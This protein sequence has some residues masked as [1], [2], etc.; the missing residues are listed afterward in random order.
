[1]KRRKRST[2]SGARSRPAQR[3]ATGTTRAKRPVGKPAAKKKRT[4]RKPA[5]R[6]T[7][8]RKGAAKKTPRRASDPL[9]RYRGKRDFERTREPSGSAAVAASEQLRFV[10]HK[11]AA[12]R[13]HYDLR[14]ELDGTFKS[15]AVTRGPSLDPKERRL[16]V[17]VE[18]H[19][20][21]YGDFE[22]TIPQGEYGGGT[23]QIWDRGYWAP[24]GDTPPQQALRDGTLRFRLD[25]ERLRGSWVLVRL[26][27]DRAKKGGTRNNWLLIKR[28]D[29]QA[30]TA[31]ADDVLAHDT[32][33]ASGRPL[34]QI[35]AGTGP[36]PE[37]FMLRKPSGCG[38]SRRAASGTKQAARGG[39]APAR[40]K[41]ASGATAMPAFVPPQLAVLRD[42]APVGDG[43][44][45]EIKLDGYRMQLRVEAGGAA[46]L[47]RKGLDWTD[48]FPR[49]ARAASA[50][51]DCIIDGE[52]VALRRDGTT[53]FAALQAAIADGKTDD[54][55]YF[56]FDLLFEDGD[57]LRGEPL[58][59]RKKRLQALL[60][61][62]RAADR[63]VLR[64]VEHFDAPG[65]A[66][67]RSACRMSLE[68]II[69][70]RLDAPY[71][72]GRGG[73]WAKTKC[74]GGQEVVI[75]GWSDTDGRFRSLLVG[76]PDG[77]RLVYAGR[78]GTGFGRDA[79]A[80]LL[81]R[82]REHAADKSPFT[83]PNAPRPKSGVHWLA[84]ALVA[85]IEFAGWTSDGL[86]RQ[87]AFK[88]LRED[89]TPADVRLERPAPP[90]K[91]G[92][93][94]PGAGGSRRGAASRANDRASN[95]VLGVSISNPDKPL[96]P[97]GGDG[98]PVTKLE[99]AR[100]YE[101]LGPWMITHL[102]GRPC[103]IIRAPDGI[104]GQR[105]FQRHAMRGTSSLLTLTKVEGD[106]EPYLQIDSL[107]ALIAV[108]QL[109]AVE[110]HPWN[111]QPGDPARPGRLVFDIDPAPG[112][113]FDR[114][115][116]AALEL[117]E[118]IEA[119]GLVAF[120]KTTGGKGL[121]VVTPLT[122]ASGRGSPTWADAKAFAHALCLAMAG[123]SPTRYLV[124]MSKKQRE[125]RIFLDYLR[126]DRMATAVAPLSPRARER[127]PVSMPVNWSQV[128][129]GLDPSRY[130]LR[131]AHGLLAR[132]APWT[133]Y[134]ESERPLADAIRRLT[135]DDRGRIATRPRRAAAR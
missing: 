117:R 22:G 113:A 88:G 27:N 107:E 38:R 53:D 14:L 100:Y 19:P 121:H 67:L 3:R 99:L 51:P 83:G 58:V 47:T 43:W 55:V 16:A 122:S 62:V 102:K 112:V 25:G 128:R 59:E 41:R 13:L 15:W 81:P 89:K 32:S 71:R 63:A 65:D 6:A 111:C 68:G 72:P 97:D 2:R 73:D 106:R 74:R 75:G 35:A 85:E 8:A 131:T 101:K 86:V 9:A 91:A 134:C 31:R 4:A 28:R 69:S 79:V 26:A 127:A 61:R 23:V 40:R 29:A 21:D 110:L 90:E 34:A 33:V 50:L 96:W 10:V 24:E 77:D 76:I 45:H 17:E 12:S 133:D 104:G 80:R 39:R 105:F 57:D 98:T 7:A 54:L 118:R 125:G 93:A 116:A 92:L 124:T 36:P 37:P 84:P 60:A 119:C 49:I 132:A 20:L 18:D 130:T 11:H 135:G 87:A 123:D 78:V 64:Y 56:A 30:A 70:K 94:Q 115:I 95:V 42:R 5:A 109:G 129:R 126:N 120:C 108:A 44:G 103:S 46:L 82:L 1:V 114:V 66:V 52:I 48:R